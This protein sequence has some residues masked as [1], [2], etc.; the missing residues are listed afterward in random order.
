M[1]RQ[2]VT[3][4]EPDGSK[5][6]YEHRSR[7]VL[8]RAVALNGA[9]RGKALASYVLAKARD[10]YQVVFTLAE[11]DPQFADE[12]IIVADK[13]NGKPLAERAGPL[14]LEVGN[15][16]A[17]RPVCPDARIAGIRALA[18]IGFGLFPDL[19]DRVLSRCRR[20]PPIISVSGIPAPGGIMTDHGEVYALGSSMVTSRSMW[21]KSMR[22]NPR[23]SALH[24]CGDGRCPSSHRL[25]VEPGRIHHEP[26]LPPT[27]QS[28]T[29]TK[30]DSDPNYAAD[31]R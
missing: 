19:V 15:D 29:R 2:T 24:R 10:G 30:P 28:N 31:H 7:E 1:P 4:T 5:S 22:R 21:P 9:L 12:P 14:R 16:K 23:R 20:R 13:Q 6:S 25:V 8:K 27:C 17:G 11:V 26:C 18:K 3:V